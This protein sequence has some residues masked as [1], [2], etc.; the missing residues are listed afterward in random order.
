MANYWI[1]TRDGGLNIHLEAKSAQAATEQAARS[2]GYSDFNQMLNDLNYTMAQVMIVTV[3]DRTEEGPQD[4][5]VFSQLRKKQQQE[6]AWSAFRF[7][8]QRTRGAG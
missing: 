1:A 8:R 6:S 7:L 4:N 3:E 2:K 5:H